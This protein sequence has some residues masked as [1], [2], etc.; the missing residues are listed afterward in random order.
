MDTVTTFA[1]RRQES[2]LPPAVAPDP[3]CGKTLAVT[4]TY[5]LSEE[6]RKA[7]LLA[8]GA[9]RARQ[10]LTVHVPANR[11][12]LVR[13]DPEGVARLRLRPRYQLDEGVRLRRVDEVP[14]YDS[15]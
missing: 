10:E 2:I 13:V 12:H 3:E 9:G 5:L 1:P 6:G 4:V 11:L 14:T 8:G 7:L 15:P